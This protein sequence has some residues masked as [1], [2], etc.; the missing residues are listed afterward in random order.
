MKITNRYNKVESGKEV[1]AKDVEGFVSGKITTVGIEENT[2]FGVPAVKMFVD[3]KGEKGGVIKQTMFFDLVFSNGAK[4]LSK[5]P[6]TMKRLKIATDEQ[7]A[8]FFAETYDLEDLIPLIEGFY[9][10]EIKFKTVLRNEKFAIDY[11]SVNLLDAPSSFRV[12]KR[13]AS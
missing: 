1:P 3:L 8:P 9:D 6:R 4:G 12:L 7:M 13:K 5:L 11:D 2:K 10:L